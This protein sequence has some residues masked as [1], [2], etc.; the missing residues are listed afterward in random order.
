MTAAAAPPVGRRT[1]EALLDTHAGRLGDRRLMLVHGHYPPTAAPEF[2]VRVGEETRRV[3]VVDRSS[4]LGILQAWHDHQAATEGSRDLLVV[5]T[6]VD[7][8][9]L[10]WDIRGH[11]VR[12]RT[13]TVDKVE[14]V[15]QRFGAAELDLR[16]HHETWLLD[17]LVDAEPS[18]GWPRVGAV[19]TRDAAMR[20]LLTARLGL[21]DPEGTDAAGRNGAPD[22]GS[23]LAWSR[24]AA[25]PHTYAGLPVRERHE[26]KK[27]LSQ[28]AGPAASVLMSLAEAGRAADAVPLGLLG[29][30]L[31]DPAASPDTALAVGG[32]LGQVMPSRGELAAFTEAVEGT[33][34]RWIG[35]AQNHDAARQQVF[36]VIERAERLAADAGLTPHL[37]ANRFLRSSFATQLR[38]VAAAARR[39]PGEAE[40]ALADLAGHALARLYPRRV[41]VAEMAVRVA[42][43]LA[44]PEPRVTSVADG[45]RA[46]LADWGWVDRALTVLWAG[47]PDGDPATTGRD[48]RA[49]YDAARARREALDEEFARRLAGWTATATAQHPGGALVVENVLGHAVRPLLGDDT[50]APL[51]VVLDGMS[52]AVA[53]QLGEEIEREGWTEAVPTPERGR[54]PA[55]SAAVAMLP[56]V[57]AVSRASLLTGTAVKGGQ[58]VETNGFTTFFRRLRREATLFHKASIA[59]PAG[60]FLAEEVMVALASDA[61]VG[62]VLNTIDDALDKGQ[63]GPRTRW[64]LDSVTYLRELLAA[65]KA[66]GRPVV[67]VA[68]HGHVLDRGSDRTDATGVDGA[69]RWRTGEPGDGE[70]LLRGPRVLEGGGTIVA[71]WREDIRY[72][73]RRAGY[74]GGTTPAEVTVPLLVLVPSRET[75]P[76]N[77][78]P[79]PREAV[80]PDWWNASTTRL[81]AEPPASEPPASEPPP[82][83]AQVTE[84][85]IGDGPVPQPAATRPSTRATTPEEHAGTSTTPNAPEPCGTTA[86]HVPSDGASAAPAAAAP[87][88]LGTRVVTSEIYQAHRR[89]VRKPPEPEVVAAVVDALTAAGGTMSPAAL[90]AAVLPAG[91]ARRSIDGF[92]ATVQRLL[93]VEGYPVLGLVDS[94]HTVKL[95]VRL[96]TEQFEVPEDQP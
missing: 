87:P 26:L 32:L 83:G 43:W 19:L 84:P 12:R 38:G 60:H 9:Q 40:S 44:Q 66:Y 41:A 65:A 16:M 78:V 34:T 24:T 80:T 39:S 74:H 68:D 11:A 55:R 93:N 63:E 89:H 59:G 56:S 5:T 91:R 1:I 73:G 79:L 76:K 13:L 18:G 51:L 92:I 54:A 4:I 58:T 23:L 30:V 64:T 77:W 45:V 15:K 42:R 21:G 57:T 7:D 47:D 81:G 31:R 82:T 50:P 6:A 27:W 67:L 22:A 70:V 28:T 90:V 35:Q 10:G 33:L 2:T 49:L 69:A 53:V 8:A 36:A 85:P 96:L 20:S 48:L 95:D 88:S 14:I 29:G 86:A 72:T 3:H 71:P 52:A 75:V 37:R 94:G 46:H 25:G 17:A 62:V 61:V